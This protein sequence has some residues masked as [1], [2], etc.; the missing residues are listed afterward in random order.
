M[1]P[2]STL[3]PALVPSRA[4]PRT[5]GKNR[6]DAPT[7]SAADESLWSAQTKIRQPTFPQLR[8]PDYSEDNIDYPTRTLRPFCLSGASFAS[9]APRHPLSLTLSNAWADKQVCRK[10]PAVPRHPF[11]PLP[12][13]P[14]L[15]EP[16]FD[17]GK[18]FHLPALYKGGF[19]RHFSTLFAFFCFQRPRTV[20]AP[21]GGRCLLSHQPSGSRILACANPRWPLDLP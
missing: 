8:V 21:A 15:G 14:P 6:F 18:R 13:K 10:I 20:R 4:T 1:P 19:T 9:H 7:I 5:A 11:C 12:R 17:L 3:P 2:D 16:S